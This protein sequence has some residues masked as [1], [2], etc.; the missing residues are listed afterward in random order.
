MPNTRE[1]AILAAAVETVE[2]KHPI[3]QVSEEGKRR[4]PRVVIY[5]AEMPQIEEEL[6][7]F[8]QNPSEL[9]DGKHIAYSRIWE[10]CAE[11]ESSP[12]F[13]PEDSSE[14]QSDSEY[15]AVIPGWMNIAAQTS[16]GGRDLVQED[17]PDTMN[18]SDEES[19]NE[20]HGDKLTGMYENGL[21]APVLI[22]QSEAARQKAA[23]SYAKSVG[24]GAWVSSGSNRPSPGSEFSDSDLSRAQSAPS[25]PASTRCGSRFESTDPSETLGSVRPPCSYPDW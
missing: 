16:V 2:W 19:P 21:K 4:T 17:G 18:S 22:S 10:K 20:E 9:E 12:I 13:L 3:E 14:I 25:W 5:P 15:A 23:W 6:N 7:E 1:S 8:S 11:Y 24:Y